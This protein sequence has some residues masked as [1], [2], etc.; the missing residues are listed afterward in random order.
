MTPNREQSSYRW[1]SDQ[2][3]CEGVQVRTAT[4]W[5]QSVQIVYVP[6]CPNEQW[7]MRNGWLGWTSRNRQHGE[8]MAWSSEVVEQYCEKPAAAEPS[9]SEVWIAS[10][11]GEEPV[12][13]KE[14]STCCHIPASLWLHKTSGHPDYGECRLETKC[15]LLSVWARDRH[16]DQFCWSSF[17]KTHASGTLSMWQLSSHTVTLQ[18]PAGESWVQYKRLFQKECQSNLAFCEV[19]TNIYLWCIISTVSLNQ[20]CNIFS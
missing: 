18:R 1:C 7:Q 11:Q 10:P 20:S 8:R 3:P 4:E 12:W 2:S 14:R 16:K 15:S 17:W 6:L 19:K 9:P 13:E 5:L